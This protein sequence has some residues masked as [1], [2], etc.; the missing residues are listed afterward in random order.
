[1]RIDSCLYCSSPNTTPEAQDVRKQGVQEKKCMTIIDRSVH[2][3][4]L[5]G[6]HAK[7]DRLCL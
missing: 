4:I 5:G 7:R 3:F 1:M 6:D 2:E